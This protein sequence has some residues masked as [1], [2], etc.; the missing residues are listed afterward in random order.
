MTLECGE[1]FFFCAKFYAIVVWE[2]CVRR[3]IWIYLW[4]PC[5]FLKSPSSCVAMG[6]TGGGGGD[7]DIFHIRVGPVTQH[8]RGRGGGIFHLRVG[9]MC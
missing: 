6:Q 1:G 5:S 2:R 8:K 3:R 4:T 7:G 9:R